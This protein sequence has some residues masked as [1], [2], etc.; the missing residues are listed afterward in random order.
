MSAATHGAPDH[1]PP[2]G[3]S[4]RDTSSDNEQA[5]RNIRHGYSVAASSQQRN[6]H[7]RTRSK[8]LQGRKPVAEA[9]GHA[10]LLQE[11]AS[12]AFRDAHKRAN[13]KSNPYY[14][15]HVAR[16]HLRKEKLS[17]VHHILRDDCHWIPMQGVYPPG[18]LDHASTASH[19][20]TWV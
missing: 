3:S 7:L 4:D 16:V 10:L 5:N 19:G 12:Q 11:E 18:F 2:T 6:P 13:E 20:A 15:D 17:R 8:T 14:Q 1:H 9:A